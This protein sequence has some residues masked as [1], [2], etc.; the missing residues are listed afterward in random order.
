M[1][2]KGNGSQRSICPQGFN[3]MLKMSLEWSG[4]NALLEVYEE[5]VAPERT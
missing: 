1:K 4:A 3:K 2:R 5:E